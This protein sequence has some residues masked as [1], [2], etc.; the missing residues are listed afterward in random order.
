MVDLLDGR[1]RALRAVGYVVAYIAL[2]KAT[3]NVVLENGFSPWYPPAGI[4]LAYLLLE[5]PRAFPVALAARWLNTWL[6]FPDAWRERARWCDRAGLGRRRHLHPGGLHPAACSSRPSAAARAGLVRVGRRDRRAACSRASRWRGHHRA[7]RRRRVGGVRLGV[8][9][10][11][12]RRR[13]GGVHRPRRAA[14]RG[15]V[16]GAGA[17]ATAPP[18]SKRPGRGARAGV[19]A[20]R[21]TGAGPFGGRAGRRDGLPRAGGRPGRVGGAAARPRG[22]GGRPS[23]PQRIAVVR[24]HPGAR[25]DGGALGA[26]SGDARGIARRAST[27]RR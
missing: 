7:R 19:G 10:L 6:L 3:E 27:S 23:R 21:G 13:S 25:C 11:G 18:E 9:V 1:T 26:A 5:G 2:A 8:D 24:G 20:R 15:L 22:G 4:T 12:R 14:G 16:G 17:A